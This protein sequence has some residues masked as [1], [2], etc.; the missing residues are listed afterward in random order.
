[1]AVTVAKRPRW[2]PA[3][4]FRSSAWWARAATIYVLIVLALA[5][6]ERASFS[7]AQV[8][9]AIHITPADGTFTIDGTR[10]ALQWPSTPTAVTFLARGPCLYRQYRGQPVLSLPGM[11]ARRRHIQLLAGGRCPPR[12]RVGTLPSVTTPRGICR[13]SAPAWARHHNN[14]PGCP[15]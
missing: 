6:V 8:P 7:L 9:L 12:R 2:M 5:G 15:A 3:R 1:M 10:L 13:R 11:D 14:R 4:V